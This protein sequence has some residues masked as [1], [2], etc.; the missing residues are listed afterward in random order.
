MKKNYILDTNVLIQDEEAIYRFEDNNVYIPAAVTDELNYLKEDYRNKERA[1][2]ARAAN[3]VIRN[4]LNECMANYDGEDSEN[5]I[6]YHKENGGSIH[7]IESYSKEYMDTLATRD[8]F[9]SEI[10]LTA[11]YVRDLDEDIPTILVTNDNGMANRAIARFKLQ[12]EEYK[13]QMVKASYKGRRELKDVPGDALLQLLEG[14]SV[15]L[16]ELGITDASENEYFSLIGDN[17]RFCLVKAS[18]GLMES[19]NMSEIKISG[20]RPVNNAQRFAFDALLSCCP[21][22]IIQGPA[23]TGKTLLALAAGMEFLKEGKVRQL[24]LLRPNV[25]LDD[26]DAALPGNEQEK[27]DPLMRPYWDNLK[28]ILMA[29]G[30]EYHKVNNKLISLISE[31]KIRV[32]SF[33]Y[34]RGRNISDTYIIC[35]ES[36][37]LLR[38]H[39]VGILTRPGEN[40]KLVMIGDP[41]EDQIDNP[42][43]NQYTNG[44]V[45]A[46][47]LMKDSEYCCQTSFLECESKRSALVKDVVFRIQNEH[48][49]GLNGK[50]N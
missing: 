41:S 12:V 23:G 49:H 30:Y 14:N 34:I 7:F 8:P 50:R 24:L 28:R 33:S 42:Y 16:D 15:P 32:E 1:A 26:N 21:L 46:M 17:G 22:A 47:N 18:K 13:N 39:A 37:N 38:K 44:L 9:D 43:V 3:R 27:I 6:V 48:L 10:I 25:M 45:Y 4:V 20:I 19:I 40:S 5:G 29:Q 11:V 2:S 35:D 36:Q 31:E